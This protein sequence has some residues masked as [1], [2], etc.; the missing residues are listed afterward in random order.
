MIYNSTILTAV[1]LYALT[2]SLLLCHSSHN[3]LVEG[4]LTTSF[5]SRSSVA[6]TAR[7]KSCE[8][9]FQL[10]D[11]STS[12]ITESKSAQKEKPVNE[13]SP[14]RIKIS[15]GRF[16]VPGDY[17]VHEDYGIGRYLGLRYVHIAPASITPELSKKERMKKS[18]PVVRVQYEDAEVT[19]FLKF[20]GEQRKL[21]IK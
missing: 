2:I 20:A 11:T 19:W 3:N 21:L 15:A 8:V 12:S 18:V 16:I 6:L 4:L 10:Y 1:I 5:L 17:I 13:N 14:E 9:N 7:T